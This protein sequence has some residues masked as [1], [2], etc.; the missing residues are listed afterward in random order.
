MGDNREGKAVSI[1]LILKSLVKRPFLW[2][3]FFTYKQLIPF[4]HSMYKMK[5]SRNNR[6]FQYQ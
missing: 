1:V 6:D 2:A 3:L 5:K 4:L